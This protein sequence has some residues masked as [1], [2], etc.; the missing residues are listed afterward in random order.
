MQCPGSHW[1]NTAPTRWEF[2]DAYVAHPVVAH[3]V[4]PA[5]TH[6]GVLTARRLSTNAKPPRR[7]CADAERSLSSSV[8]ITFA[9]AGGCHPLG[10][11]WSGRGMRISAGDLRTS[12]WLR[13][14]FGHEIRGNSV[15]RRLS[16]PEVPTN[17]AHLSVKGARRAIA[18]VSVHGVVAQE[19][20]DASPVGSG[21]GDADT[22]IVGVCLCWWNAEGCQCYGC[23]RR[24]RCLVENSVG[25]NRWGPRPVVRIDL[26][27]GGTVTTG[28][29]TRRS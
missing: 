26:R 14:V 13:R 9:A 18:L 22:G 6:R 1:C 19:F 20:V 16:D 25:E 11:R 4:W 10:V 5:T 27:D 24:R 12:R 23:C 29:N 7:P 15:R 21:I 3:P 2:A 28:G 17:L 8:A